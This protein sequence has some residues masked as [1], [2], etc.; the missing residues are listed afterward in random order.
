MSEQNVRLRVRLGQSEVEVEA[1]KEDLGQIFEMIPELMKKLKDATHQQVQ[2][3]EELS[4]ASQPS[5]TVPPEVVFGKSESLPSM[6]LKLFSS[7][8]GKQP[9]KLLE[10]KEVLETYG[11]VYPKQSVAV[12]LLRLAKEGKLRRFKQP[13]GE[14]V[15]TIPASLLS[16][17]F[18]TESLEEAKS[19][20]A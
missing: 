10:I 8:W 12:A 11:L 6:I 17:E 19:E 14:Y 5:P 2:S 9:R 18:K 13:D 4:I 16:P 20:Q 15:Y 1:R 7:G 3:K